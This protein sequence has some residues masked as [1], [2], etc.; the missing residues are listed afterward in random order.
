MKETTFQLFCAIE[1]QVRAIL[2]Q[3]KNPSQPSKAEI[4]QNVTSDDDVQFYWL[5]ASADFD[6]HDD[7]EACDI[8][9]NTVSHCKRVFP[10]WSL[11]G[12][13]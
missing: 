4:I 5:I 10:S 6:I 12:E 13:V 2:N 7:D 9:L 11:D 1:Y 3:L 8:L